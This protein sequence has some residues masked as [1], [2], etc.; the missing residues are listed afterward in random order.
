MVERSDLYPGAVVTVRAKVREYLDDVDRYTLE[1]ISGGTS[2]PF[3][4]ILSVEPRPLKV[5]DPVE[6]CGDAGRIAL[7]HGDQAILLWTDVDPAEMNGRLS[8]PYHVDKLTRLPEE[9][10]P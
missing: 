3:A 10:A 9:R 6:I 4:D 5:G 1:P 2:V 7:I 8:R